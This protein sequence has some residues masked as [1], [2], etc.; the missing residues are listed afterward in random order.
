MKDTS[1]LTIKQYQ[2]LTKRLVIERGFDQETVPEVF[3]LLVEEIGELAKAIRKYNGQ[4]VDKTSLV[5]NVEDEAAD[6]FWLLLDLCNRL[7][8][9]LG[10]SYQAKEAKNAK[11]TWQ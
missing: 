11:R 6:V 3:T 2:E 5:H 9:D 1:S 4:K 7:N 8:I 10:N